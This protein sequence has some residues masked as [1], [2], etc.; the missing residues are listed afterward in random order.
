MCLNILYLAH[1]QWFTC[2][3]L[4]FTSKLWVYYHILSCDKKLSKSQFSL[5]HGAKNKK[6]ATEATINKN[7][8]SLLFRINVRSQESMEP[9]LK[10]WRKSSGENGDFLHTFAL[11]KE[12]F[13]KL[14]ILCKMSKVKYFTAVEW[15]ITLLSVSFFCRMCSVKIYVAGCIATCCVCCREALCF[16]QGSCRGWRGESVDCQACRETAGEWVWVKCIGS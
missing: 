11:L 6:Q 5:A 15:T 8:C 10:E 16:R 2:R 3:W 1:L 14:S 7:P 13:S 12:I 9:V 4:K